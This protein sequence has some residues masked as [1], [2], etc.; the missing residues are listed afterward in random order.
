[1]TG[2]PLYLYAPYEDKPWFYIEPADPSQ[3][4]CA[5]P[6]Y[7]AVELRGDVSM[8]E[9]Y[10]LAHEDAGSSWPDLYSKAQMIEFAKAYVA[11]MSCGE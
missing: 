10:S 6:H 8:P 9:P 2:K 3:Y 5:V 7:K 4:P 11:Q 1:M